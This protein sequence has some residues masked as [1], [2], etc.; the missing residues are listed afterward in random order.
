MTYDLWNSSNSGDFK[1]D[2]QRFL[3]VKVNCPSYVFSKSIWILRNIKKLG[4]IIKSARK[5]A[6]D[7]LF[8]FASDDVIP[9]KQTRKKAIG[10]L[11][12][13][14]ERWIFFLHL[15]SNWQDLN[16]RSASRSSSAIAELFF[17]QSWCES[18]AVY[19]SLVWCC[20]TTRWECTFVSST[21]THNHKGL[22][23]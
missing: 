16:W 5:C 20:C 12:E 15:Y 7:E 2:M 18:F 23:L 13:D 11:S 1:D 14:V 10:V 4:N 21:V 8:T 6:P 9:G 17:V 22:D 3:V 19:D